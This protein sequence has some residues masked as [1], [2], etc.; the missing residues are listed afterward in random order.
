[1][2]FSSLR[3][4]VG[5]LIALVALAAADFELYRY[6]TEDALISGLALSSSCLAALN[7]TV[8]CNETSI[9]TLGNGADIHCKSILA[10][11]GPNKTSTLT[12]PTSSVWTTSDVNYL[13]TADC[14]ASLDSWQS[15]V[16]T[17]CADET[18]VQAGVIV[19]AKALPLQFTYNAGLVCMKDSAS[20]WCFLESQTWQGSDYIRWDPAMCY[21]NGN[22]NSTVAPQC[23]DPDFDVDTITSEMSAL[24]NI[25]DE[26]LYCNECFLELYR[27]RLLNPWL[28]ITNFTDYLIEQFDDVQGNC[29]TTLPYSTSSSTLYVGTATATT[30]TT[31]SG[32]TTAP[33]TTATCLGQTVQPLSNWL[34]CNDLCDT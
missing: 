32:T 20:N 22:D 21:S 8:L 10:S 25:Y 13:C 5:L 30:T 34:T 31:G 3:S 18:T 7:A 11:I 9:A 1:M 28:P 19:Q 17:V 23:S 16:E 27:Q 15:N 14:V 33:T 2:M 24:T 29:S 4:R 6:Y 12:S 26:D